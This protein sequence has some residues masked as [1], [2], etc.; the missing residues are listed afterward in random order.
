M[1]ISRVP[2]ANQPARAAQHQPANDYANQQKLFAPGLCPHPIDIDD[3]RRI[4][5]HVALGARWARPKQVIEHHSRLLIG[6]TIA[7][8]VAMKIPD[9]DNSAASQ[10]KNGLNKIQNVYAMSSRIIPFSP[11]ARTG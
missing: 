11:T 2:R 6:P 1:L 5:W 10:V 7:Q 4:G 8:N 9:T 3:G